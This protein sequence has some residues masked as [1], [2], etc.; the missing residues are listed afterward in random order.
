M[1]IN[2]NGPLNG[3]HLNRKI[4]NWGETF[5]IEFDIFIEK[6]DGMETN[7]GLIVID[8]EHEINH[9]SD[10]VVVLFENGHLGFEYNHGADKLSVLQTY[11]IEL[12]TNYHVEFKQ[13]KTSNE[14]TK[15]TIKLNEK[16]L[17]D[18]EVE[19]VY[20]ITGTLM[21]GDFNENHDFGRLSNVKIF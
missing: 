19:K 7:V 6:I 20:A 12:K 3:L 2:V 21:V 16:V 11:E 10:P 5:T 17:V 8:H 14:K 15:R 1:L 4:E 13:F 9:D 18:K